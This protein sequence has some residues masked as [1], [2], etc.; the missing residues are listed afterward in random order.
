M[1]SEQPDLRGVIELVAKNLVDDPGEVEVSEIKGAQT[2]VYELHV[3][4]ADI[5]KVIG[6]NGRNAQA[7]RTLIY[8]IA[9]KAGRKVVLEIIEGDKDFQ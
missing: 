5:G 1:G 4:K 2:T 6:K 8:C 9:A 3:G 7:L